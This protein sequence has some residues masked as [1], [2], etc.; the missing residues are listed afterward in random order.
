MSQCSFRGCQ[1]IIMLGMLLPILLCILIYLGLFL[2]IIYSTYKYNS[3]DIKQ[4]QIMQIN[5]LNRWTQAQVN[6]FQEQA[7]NL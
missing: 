2:H 4:W 6:M 3:I 5:D 7:N 1:R